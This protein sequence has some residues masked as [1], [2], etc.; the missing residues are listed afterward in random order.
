MELKRV[1]HHFPYSGIS[2][3]AAQGTRRPPRAPVPEALASPVVSDGSCW[4]CCAGGLGPVLAVPGGEQRPRS[5]R[6]CWACLN[7]HPP[8][9]AGLLLPEP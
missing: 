8:L 9:P 5:E 3:A 6:L 7:A 1:T 2:L 4:L